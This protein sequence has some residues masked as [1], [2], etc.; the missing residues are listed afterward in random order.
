MRVESEN[1][2][3]PGL[4]SIATYRSPL[5]RTAMCR[6]RPTFFTTASA[7]KPAGSVNPALSGSHWILVAATRAPVAA[8]GT[9]VAGDVGSLQAIVRA[10][11]P[12]PS[13]AAV[14]ID[15]RLHT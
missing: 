11:S 2:V 6:A 1:P 15:V 10:E 7:Q 8:T 12:A 3:V 9:D 14:R 5:G 4:L 13:G